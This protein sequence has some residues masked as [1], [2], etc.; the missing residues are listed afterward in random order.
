VSTT[1]VVFPTSDEIEGFWNLDKMHAPRPITPLSFDLIIET[2]AQGFTKAQAEYDCPIM[3]TPKEI[4]H[5]VYVSFHPV[6]DGG[7]IEDRLSRYQDTLAAKVPGVGKL[8]DEEW[9]PT[10]I[11][12]NEPA[13]TADYSGLSDAELVKKLEEFTDHM[14]YQWW[15]HGHIN[16]VLLSSSA[17]CD[18]YDEVMQPAEKTEAY[19][20][21]QGFH[22]RSV[23]V[24]RA[25][26]KLSRD[27]KNSPTLSKL[28]A[29]KASNEIVAELDKSDDGRVFHAKLREFLEEFGWRSDAVYD[30]ADIPWRED[31]SIAL[32]SIAGF[33]GLDDSE[34][35][36]RHYQT[37]VKQREELLGKVRAKLAN[38]PE[39]LAKFD[40][41]Y[42]A[43]RYSFP[44]TEDHAFY[45]DQLGVGVF[46]RFAL[47]VGERLVSKGVFDKPD[48]VFFL[49]APEVPDALLNGGDRRAVVAERRATFE[50]AGK[51]IAPTSI[52]NPPEIPADAPPDPFMDALVFRLLGMVPPDDNPDPNI[53][54]AVA[55]S[56]GVLTGKARVVR[57]LAEAGDLEEGEIMVCEMTLPPW[58]PYFSIAG[59]VV[60]DVGGVLSHCAIV[61]REFGVPAVVGSV[62]GTTVIKTGQTITVDGNNGLVYLDGRT[63]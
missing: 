49:R 57:S 43:A 22:T 36:E 60:S 51:V 38:D 14:R 2:L 42:E 44:V 5:Y 16:F 3:V 17:L 61:A 10:V 21:L 15:I 4:N 27:V 18:M 50:A 26:W 58:V 1:E 29:D 23:D 55:G 32:S 41:L 40:E 62:T 46:R 45:I 20:T 47:A 53:I 35:P 7:V 52:G 6:A 28:F 39:K 48:D 33:V 63:L 9:K 11:A 13:K 12:K 54:R 19:Q 59:A 25:M 8:W 34:D 56:P 37:A 24:S 30:L 31:E